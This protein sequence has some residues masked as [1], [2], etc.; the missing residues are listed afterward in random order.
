M[1]IFAVNMAEFTNSLRRLVVSLDSVK[2]R[3]EEGLFKAEGT[4]CVSDTIDAF[5][6]RHLIAT[7]RWINDNPE[8]GQRVTCVC[9]GRELERMSS[10]KSPQGVIAVYELPDMADPQLIAGQPAIALDSLQDPGNLGTIM[11][12]ADWFGVSRIVAS[13]DTVDCFSPKV[14]QATMGA[15]SRVRVCYTSLPEFLK[16]AGRTVI[17]TF[18]D[19]DNIMSADMPQDAILVIGNEGRGIS[20]EVERSVMRR[21]TI[22]PYSAGGPTSE[23]LNAA[24]AAS[25]SLALLRRPVLI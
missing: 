23:S 22:P 24:V 14:V 2:H 11:R 17:G 7:E 21:L 15:I 5:P 19:G 8:L 25:I 6:L 9:P 10:L 18:L 12:V 20:A 13:N 1:C 4:K 16:S 3:R